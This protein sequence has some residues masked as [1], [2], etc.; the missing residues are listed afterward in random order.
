MSGGCSDNKSQW[1][2]R[3]GEADTNPATHRE[4]EGERA[5]G[6]EKQHSRSRQ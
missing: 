3:R 4:A 6:S 2:E 1:R 5:N